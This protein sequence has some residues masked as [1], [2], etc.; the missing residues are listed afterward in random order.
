MHLFWFFNNQE[1]ILPPGLYYPVEVELIG[2][3]TF[4][5]GVFDHTTLAIFN[6]GNET[7]DIITGVFGT[8]VEFFID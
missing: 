2:L 1:I 3:K 5:V 8:S 6:D 7:I 4:N